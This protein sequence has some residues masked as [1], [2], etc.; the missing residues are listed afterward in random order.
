MI[1]FFIKKIINILLQFFLFIIIP[2]SCSVI[3]FFFYSSDFKI[4][5]KNNTDYLYVYDNKKKTLQNFDYVVEYEKLPKHLIEAFISIED[6]HFFTHYGFSLKSIIRSFWK[7]IK[8]KRFAQGGSTITEQYMKLY[9]GDLKK[10]ISRKIK[11][12][13]MSIIIEFYYS[14][15]EI[16]QGY[17]NL[18]YFGK[19][20]YGIANA[21]RI[22]FNKNYQ[23]LTLTESAL[24][25]GII[26]RPEHF[27]PIKKYH[28]A[29][30]RRNLVLKRM[31]LEGYISENIYE[32][33]INSENKVFENN[34]FDFNKSI[35]QSIEAEIHKKQ[36]SSKD[37]YSVFTTI[38]NNIQKISI[39][40]FNQHIHELKKVSPHIEG[41][42]II[43]EYKTGKIIALINGYNLSYQPN[44]VFS[45]RKQIGSII[46]PYIFYFALENGD[47]LQTEYSDIPLEEK[48]SWTPYNNNKKFKG[49]MSIEQALINSNNIIPIRILDKYKVKNFIP[50][51]QKFFTSPIS[52][53]LSLALG[54]IEAT[55]YTV[56]SLFNTILNEGIK[57]D[58][59]YIEKIIKKSGGILYDYEYD[60]EFEQNIKILNEES[61]KKIKSILEKIGSMLCQKYSLST[62]QPIYA[63]TGTTNNAVSCWFVCANETYSI[64]IVIGTDINEKLSQYGI[65][66]TKSV[67]PLGLKILEKIKKE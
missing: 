56:L 66:S 22:F 32:K 30:K 3:L 59:Y 2:L 55:P 17:A 62:K 35:I 12:F 34:Y 45:W 21:S 25:A 4:F 6:T 15:E 58:P 11:N 57:N 47:S 53:Y 44:R 24:I 51:I 26:Q 9:C 64:A 8:E 36:F 41:A 39:E 48:F 19:N 50:L 16:F 49:E 20:I 43:S 65:S 28:I 38:E 27:N 40:L 7:N 37:E 18:L 33:A 14:K 54:C 5:I 60:Q 61:T 29:I 10:T 23:D 42:L 63:K 1:V 31:F 67:A 13:L 46:K 52:P